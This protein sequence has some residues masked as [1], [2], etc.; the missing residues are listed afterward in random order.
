MEKSGAFSVYGQTSPTDD[1]GVKSFNY[2]AF[3]ETTGRFFFPSKYRQSRSNSGVLD[4]GTKGIVSVGGMGSNLHFA[5][6]VFS[7]F[8]CKLFIANE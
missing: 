6:F 8:S 1:I 3:L 7:F 4:F 2:A 5:T